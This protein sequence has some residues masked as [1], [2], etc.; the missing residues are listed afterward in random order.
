MV[1]T[2]RQLFPPAPHGTERREERGADARH[3]TASSNKQQRATKS[4][5]RGA[6]E[7]EEEREREGELERKKGRKRKRI[8]VVTGSNR[9]RETERERS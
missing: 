7:E 1:H 8:K 9:E 3:S 5:A 4:P 2:L 6:E